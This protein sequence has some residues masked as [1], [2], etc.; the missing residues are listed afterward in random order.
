[1]AKELFRKSVLDRMSSPEQLDQTMKVIK[2]GVWIVMLFIGILI[3]AVIVWGFIGSIPEKVQGQGVLLN[4]SSYVSLKYSASGIVKN[5][6]VY[7]GDSV[8]KNQVIAR[9]ER[10]DL[11]GELHLTEHKIQNLKKIYNST[12]DFSSKN[13]DLTAEMLTKSEKDLHTQLNTLTLKVQEAERQVKEMAKL[14]KDGLI[15]LNNYTAARN[16]LM[17]VKAEK[18]DAESKLM[19]VGL[20][21]LKSKSETER[22]LMN[23][24]NQI[25][26]AE[27]QL[28]VQRSNYDEVTKV[29]S[30]VTGVISEMVVGKGDFISAG[31]TIA[32]IDTSAAADSILEAHVYVP[33]AEGKRITNGMN[34]AISPTTFKQEE[35]G[36]IRGIVTEVSEYPVSSSYLLGVLENES[37]VKTFSE[38]QNPVEVIARLLPDQSTASGFNWSSSRGPD[39]R[40]SPGTMCSASVTVKDNHP[41]EILIPTVKKKIFGIGE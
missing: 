6:F 28:V 32:M 38:I 26:E 41:I 14:Y 3:S 24:E 40:V 12:K 25:N 18:I 10:S 1:M 11:L 19:E 17:Q 33:A 35:Y 20:N 9:I 36:Y 37:L 27:R 34:I 22:E 13:V 29:V 7:R 15:T 5:V 23:L 16:E 8:V 4:S 39:E 2:P 30:S 31:A 21:K